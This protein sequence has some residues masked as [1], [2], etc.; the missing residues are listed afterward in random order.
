MPCEATIL[1]PEA[2]S[3]KKRDCSIASGLFTL[4]S[5]ISGLG[6]FFYIIGQFR[7]DQPILKK[8]YKI[9][10]VIHY[11]FDLEEVSFFYSLIIMLI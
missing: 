11:T 5:W 6:V 2:I 3:T 4:L 1:L 7:I 9:P 8:Q 10:R